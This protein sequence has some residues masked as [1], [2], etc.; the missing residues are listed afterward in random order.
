L[1]RISEGIRQWTNLSTR[2]LL[3]VWTLPELGYLKWNVDRS[4]GTPERSGVGFFFSRDH[5]ERLMSVSSILTGIKYSNEAELIAI[6]EAMQLSVDSGITKEVNGI[7][8]SDSA[9]AISWLCMK[10]DKR[11]ETT[12]YL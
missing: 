11:Q 5:E 10:P 4:L 1:I 7:I 9:N 8:E 3:T 2:R 12:K 6:L